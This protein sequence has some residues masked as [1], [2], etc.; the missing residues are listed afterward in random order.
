MTEKELKA[1]V[2]DP[3]GGYFF[4]GDEDYLK[5]YYTALIRKAVITDEDLAVFNEISF[6]NDN[7]SPSAIEEALAA[8][9]MMTDKKLI[10]IRL[11]SYT[12]IPE[13]DKKSFLELLPS[14]ESYDD[15]VLVMSIAAEGFDAGTEKKPS[16]ALKA[17]GKHLKTVDFPLSQE[18]KLVRW[19]SR[20]FAKDHLTA[21]EA[22]LKM[23]INMCGRGMLRLSAEAEKVSARALSMGLGNVSCR[24][25]SETVTRTPEEEAFMLTNSVVAGDTEAA[26]E[27]LGRAKRRNEPPVKLLA[28]ITK[29]FCDLAIVSYMAREGMDRYAIA[30][31]LDIHHYK[32]KL[33]MQS[34]AGVSSQT[35]DEI[36]LLCAEADRAMKSGSFG[37]IPLEKLICAAGQKIRK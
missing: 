29:N 14:L 12:A 2:G 20:H 34:C 31:A 6:D 5:E 17:I 30:A 19:L 32:V 13:K 33:H 35:I 8:P 18:A 9:P 27:C 26:L 36:V 21:D 10:K 28:S 1:S 4:Y 37:Y 23:M 11:S 15:T 7:F 16:A 3:E 22:A 25:V 24:L